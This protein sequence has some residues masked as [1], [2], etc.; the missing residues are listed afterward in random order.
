M[1]ITGGHSIDAMCYC[2]GEFR[3]LSA[4]VATLVPRATVEETGE[5][6]DVTSP[7]NVLVSGVL[8]NGAVASVHIKSVPAHGT[9]FVMEVHGTE[10]ALVVS[11]DDSAQIGELTLKGARGAD[12]AMENL[13]TPKRHR[14]V[15]ASVSDGR[16]LNVAQ[17]FRRYAESLKKGTAADPDFNLAVTR[18]K[19]L[20]AIQRAS[21]T[22]QRQVL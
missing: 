22:G 18:H 20:D 10:G 19:M 15:P 1:S 14:W 21:D 2:M 11:S 7:D 16:P 5:T 13:P 6:L 3:E 12:R 17:L 8:E 9:G 4:R